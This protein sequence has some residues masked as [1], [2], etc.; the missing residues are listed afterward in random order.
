MPTGLTN[1]IAVAAGGDQSLALLSNGSVTNWG[2]N[3][4]TMP[5]NLTNIVAIAAGTNFCLA[6]RSNSTVVAWGSNGSPTNVPA[7]L[8]NVVAIAAGGGHALALKVNGTVVAWGINSSGQTNVPS[9]LTNSTA[10]AMGIGAGYAHSMALRNDGTLVEWGDN[11]LGQT[12]APNLTRVKLIAAGGNQNLASTFSTLTQY[13]VDV[14][15][16]LLLIYNTNSTD[17]SNVWAYYMANRPMVTG[18][19]VLGIGCTNN[20]TI[21]PSELPNQIFAPITNWLALNPTKRPQYVI[22]FPYIPLRLTFPH[23]TNEKP[24]RIDRANPSTHVPCVGW[25][26]VAYWLFLETTSAA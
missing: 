5:A 15:K 11:S 3:F 6:L 24:G 14:T 18:A 1:V 13:Q 26:A 25:S 2:T 21:I 9:S 12:N 23:R 19:N 4:G 22:I 17:S 10:N 16:D 7:G 20:E 8:T